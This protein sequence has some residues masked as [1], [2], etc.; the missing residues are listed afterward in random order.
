MA[1]DY[2]AHELGHGCQHSRCDAAAEYQWRRSATE[3]ETPKETTVA[4]NYGVVVRHFSGAAE[5]AV[6]SCG[7]H[8]LSPEKM[9]LRHFSSCPA[10]D[11]GCECVEVPVD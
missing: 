1:R 3:E 8:A 11:P 5:R 2:W 7:A 6:F 10:P 4:G 9:A